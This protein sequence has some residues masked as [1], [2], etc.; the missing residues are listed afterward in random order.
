MLLD[1]ENFIFPSDRTKDYTIIEISMFVGRSPE[2]KKNLIHA[3][4][5]RIAE[6]TGIRAQDLEITIFETP[7]CNWGIRGIGGDELGLD[8]QVD[9]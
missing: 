9:V 8:Y 5:Q 6:T 7:R 1:S 4:Y 2:T 3:L